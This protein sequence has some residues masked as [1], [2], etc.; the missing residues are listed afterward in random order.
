MTAASATAGHMPR[1]TTRDELDMP[2]LGLRRGL[3]LEQVR[4]DTSIRQ[5]VRTIASAETQAWWGRKTMA[6]ATCWTLVTASRPTA[7]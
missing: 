4:R 3:P 1:Q 5:R 7:A 6:S 2:P